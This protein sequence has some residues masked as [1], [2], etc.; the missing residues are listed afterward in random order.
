MFAGAYSGKR[1]LVTGHTGFKGSWLTHWLTRLGAEVAGYSLF[2]PP[3]PANFEVLDLH[4]H[5]ANHVGDVRDH[6]SLAKL[7]L[8]FRPEI[9]FHL[10]AQA[11]VRT[12]YDEPRQTFETNLCGT[13]N[14]LEALRITPSAI[15]AVMITSDKCYENVEWEWGYRESDHL[16]G[17]DPYSASKAC[18]EIAISAY[19]RSYLA[20]AAKNI[21]STR[22]GN[23]I[24]G[25]DWAVDRI[26]PDCIRAWAEQKP[27]LLRNPH[28]TRP[29][30]HVLEPL[31][32]Y[33]WLGA[34][35]LLGDPR[36]SGE[37]FNFGPQAH[38]TLSVADLVEKMAGQWPGASWECDA[39]MEKKK[40]AGLLKLNCDKA[41][42]RLGWRPALSIEECVRL[43]AEWYLRYYGGSDMR[44]QTNSQ[45]DYY[46]QRATEQ[47]IEWALS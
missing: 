6:S 23:V 31:G 5:V 34:Q 22:A 14:V 47:G 41:L 9:V 13:V 18:A 32:G 27:C 37:A 44:A 39:S 40:E 11:I 33:L 15:A 20:S 1:V 12:S 35:L 24:G 7:F 36:A 8:E 43:T 16:G 25:G 2:V 10:A 38:V 4:K 3:R 46:V 19:T 26:V 17:K 21:A 29:W 28:A 30:Q 42:S 45:I